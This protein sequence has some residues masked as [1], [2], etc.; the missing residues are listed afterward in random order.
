MKAC[1][2]LLNLICCWCLIYLLLILP[3]ILIYFIGKLSYF[4]TE[5]EVPQ[6]PPLSDLPN[7]YSTKLPQEQNYFIGRDVELQDITAYLD[8]HESSTQIIGI[9]GGPGI[10]KSTLAIKAGHAV[11]NDNVT[12]EY[13]DLSEVLY[14]PHLLHKILGGRTNSTKHAKMKEELKCWAE[15]F[16][17]SKVLIFDGCDNF[18]DSNQ[19]GE[20]Q[21][22]FDI[23][24]THSDQIKI[25]FTSKHIVTFLGQFK[26][27]TLE[28]L[29]L[30]HAVELLRILNSKLLEEDARTIANAVGNVPLALQ[31]VGALLK[32]DTISLD[33]IVKEITTNPIQVL[34]SDSL[35]E[36]HQVQTSLRISFD[37]LN[38]EYS[39]ACACFLANFPGSFSRDAAVGVLNYMVNKTYWYA[40]I[41]HELNIFHNWVPKPS[42]CLDKLVHRSLLKYHSNSDRYSFHKLIKWFLSEVQSQN[43]ESDKKIRQFKRGFVFYFSDYW[44]TYHEYVRKGNYDPYVMAA[45]DLERHNFEF[46]EKVLPELGLDISYIKRYTESAELYASYFDSRTDYFRHLKKSETALVAVK[47]TKSDLKDRYRTVMMLDLHS[48]AVISEKGAQHYMDI[49]VEM[50]IQ[51]SFFEDYLFGSKAALGSL[52]SRKGRIIE[53]H[54]IY[55]KEVVKY[56]NKFLDQMKKY[57]FKVRDIDTLIEVLQVKTGLSWPPNKCSEKSCNDYEKG[58]TYFGSGD[59]EKAIKF[60]NK[61]LKENIPEHE[62]LYT[63]VMIYYCHQFNGNN[64]KAMETVQLLDT[65]VIQKKVR[66]LVVNQKNYKKIHIVTLFYER[67]RRGTIY[68]GILINKLFMELDDRYSSFITSVQYFE[69]IYQYLQETHKYFKMLQDLS[70]NFL[71]QN[72]E[73]E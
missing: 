72:H 70:I 4:G 21:R 35:P 51:V 65:K 22:V 17:H 1:L 45:L 64:H 37:N 58:R 48:Q 43:S 3:I 67:V 62:Y 32:T 63:I 15:T 14:V 11:S 12:V 57:C 47:E 6:M 38:D 26:S 44:D 2:Y 31:V 52:N 34:S 16:T 30:E 69:E 20:V 28:E 56:V 25:I 40:Q 73:L 71:M 8:F 19:K 55:G 27:V 42:H 23:L 5:R 41:F 10:G 61:Y 53:L 13:F 49:F 9:F 39:Q 60:Y 7:Y 33:A 54:K 46:M 50:I 18:F 59:Y 36:F 29:S 68:H 66:T 24:I